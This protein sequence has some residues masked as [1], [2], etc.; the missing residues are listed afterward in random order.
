M[1]RY[2]LHGFRSFSAGDSFAPTRK[3]S[4]EFIYY[5]AARF[6]KCFFVNPSQRRPLKHGIIDDLEDQNVLD[7]EKLEQ[8][9][10]WYVSAYQYN[11]ALQKP[12]PRI[13]LNGNQ[14]GV[15]TPQEQREAV[16]W[17]TA[18]KHAFGGRAIEQAN[19]EKRP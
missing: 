13:D 11:Y 12:G 7:H 2:A 6:P 19:A 16:E 5:L 4:E 17:V 10:A 8:A 15:V 9:I 18:R 14:A 3:R 1:A